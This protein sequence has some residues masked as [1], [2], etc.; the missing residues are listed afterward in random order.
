MF[1][2]IT[3]KK[4]PSSKQAVD[5]L[6]ELN[7]NE[8]VLKLVSGVLYY[9]DIYYNLS[10]YKKSMLLMKNYKSLIEHNYIYRFALGFYATA[11]SDKSYSHNYYLCSKLADLDGHDLIN[12]NRN[13]L[14]AE[15][16]IEQ[17]NQHITNKKSC[18]SD[19]NLNLDI[20]L[21]TYPSNNYFID[22]NNLDLDSTDIANLFMT[23]IELKIDI[24]TFVFVFYIL[25]DFIHIY[26]PNKFKTEAEFNDAM[27]QIIKTH[28]DRQI[29]RLLLLLS[30]YQQI[31]LKEYYTKVLNVAEIYGETRSHNVINEELQIYD[32]I[33]ESAFITSDKLYTFLSEN[34][35][36][37]FPYVPTT[38]PRRSSNKKYKSNKTLLTRSKVVKSA[39]SATQKRRSANNQDFYPL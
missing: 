37:Y 12:K 22:A 25:N 35:S 17:I 33:L 23:F 31:L 27:T 6:P 4:S 36:K 13:I 19:P 30:E 14:G 20:K 15:I 3:R 29:I 39:N 24:Y 2:S 18:L 5:S 32:S 11:H 28:K 26:K 1:K 38:Q 8:S 16:I 34:Y 9:S 7:T 10:N 21:N